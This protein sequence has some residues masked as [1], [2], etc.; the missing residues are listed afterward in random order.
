MSGNKMIIIIHFLPGGESV[1]P[2]V[3]G[4]WWESRGADDTEGA[5]GGAPEHGDRD[6]SWGREEH[7]RG[8]CQQAGTLKVD[9]IPRRQCVTV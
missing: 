3:Q 8:A 7:S 5:G 4:D 6:A 1:Q 9:T 2:H